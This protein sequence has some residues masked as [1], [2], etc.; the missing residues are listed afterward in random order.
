MT[1]TLTKTIIRTFLAIF[2]ILMVC[3]CSKM[4]E[5][6]D[7]SFTFIERGDYEIDTYNGI[8]VY[9]FHKSNERL[10]GYYV[11][12]NELTK[13]EE[14]EVN[15]GLLQGDYITFHPNGNVYT[16][17]I[18]E[19]GKLHGE[20]KVYF[21]SGKIKKLNFYNKNELFDKEMTYFE[22]GQIKSESKV[23]NGEIIESVYYD[24]LGNIVSQKFIEN[25]RTIR[26]KIKFGK[27]VSEEIASNYD[28]F[29]ALK[30][31]DD[32]GNLEI[33]VRLKKTDNSTF[34]IELDSLENEIKRIDMRKNPEEALKYKKYFN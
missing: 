16:H 27:V 33:Y 22:S 28:N 8:T 31:Y 3:S 4:K 32:D 25:N 13:W 34:I 18:Y 29:N 1:K 20:N 19:N 2:L 7:Q 30:Y 15:N 14:F 5:R 6:H 26:Q 17:S 21:T 9:R 10:N 12:G 23:K 11:V 24:L